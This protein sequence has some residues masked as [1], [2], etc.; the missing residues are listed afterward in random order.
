M[1]KM[2]YIDMNTHTHD[3]ERLH[4]SRHKNFKS[5]TCKLKKSFNKGQNDLDLNVKSQSV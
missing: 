1:V 5:V 2:L 3:D 4:L